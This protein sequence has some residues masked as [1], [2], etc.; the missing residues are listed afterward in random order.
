LIQR[1]STQGFKPGTA[2]NRVGVS[3]SMVLQYDVDPTKGAL[4]IVAS[5]RSKR[6]KVQGQAAKPACPFCPGFEQTT[7]PATLSLPKHGKWSVRAFENKFPILDPSKPFRGFKQG[8]AFG[9]HE[10]IVETAKHGQLFQ[11]FS[12]SHLALVFEAWKDRFSKLSA[13]KGIKCTF[14]FANHGPKGGASIDHEHAQVTAL[15]FVPPILAAEYAQ[16]A[17]TGGC[18]Y[19]SLAANKK[20]RVAENKTFAAVCI[21]YSRFAYETWIIPKKH[22]LSILDFDAR[23][24]EDL[25]ELLAR[26]IGRIYPSVPNYNMAFHQ[27]SSAGKLHFHI[28]IYPRKDTW[29]G[30]ELGAGVIV[31]TSDWRNT[32]KTL[33]K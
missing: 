6:P 33:K 17:S 13:K 22:K 15:P 26:A 4:V 11:D 9:Y 14:L 29:A 8:P 20:F 19:C 31:N 10:V 2:F 28:E 32:L 23:E 1:V 30:L 16:Q 5:S 7:P 27:S 25:M 18:E 3:N 21:P 24:A 12:K